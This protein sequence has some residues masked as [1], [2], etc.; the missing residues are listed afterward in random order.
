ML[1]LGIAI[2]KEIAVP[3]HL[4]KEINTP[5][6]FHFALIFSLLSTDCVTHLLDLVRV[7]DKS[8]MNQKGKKKYKR[9]H[10]SM[11]ICHFF[12]EENIK[13]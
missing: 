5:T 13:R 9:Q 6:C 7:F 1:R 8:Q 4:S 10:S 2:Y 11:G 3:K 12:W